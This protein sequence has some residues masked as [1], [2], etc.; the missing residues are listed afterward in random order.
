MKMLDVDG[1]ADALRRD[2]LPLLSEAGRF[3]L[4]SPLEAGDPEFA[5]YLGLQFA[6]LDEVRIPEPLLEA[7]GVALDDRAFDPDLRPEATAW[8]AQ[9][10]S[11]DAADR[12]LP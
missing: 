1:I 10:R 8:C 6:L 12:N 2:L 5:I 11:G 9:L 3:I 4:W 7:I